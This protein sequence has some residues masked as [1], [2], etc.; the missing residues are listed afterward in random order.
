MNDMG[1]ESVTETAFF[2][3]ET[4]LSFE[5]ESRLSANYDVDNRKNMISE[6]K[7]EAGILIRLFLCQFFSSQSSVLRV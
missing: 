5:S 2:F 7:T 1:E 4:V 3:N 6:G